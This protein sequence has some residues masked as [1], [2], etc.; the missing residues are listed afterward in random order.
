MVDAVTVMRLSRDR[1]ATDAR[2]AKE[3]GKRNKRKAKPASRK[4]TQTP[5]DA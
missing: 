5:I 3:T 2:E 4:M 1:P